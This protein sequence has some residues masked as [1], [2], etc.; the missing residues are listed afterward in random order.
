MIRRFLAEMPWCTNRFLRRSRVWVSFGTLDARCFL[1]LTT[2]LSFCN[3]R[4]RSTR[5]LAGGG[6]IL[7][8]TD[9]NVRDK[10]TG[11]LPDALTVYL[12]SSLPFSLLFYRSQC[13]SGRLQG[14][15]YL[16]LFLP[17]HQ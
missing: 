7:A 10:P 5:I 2:L 11:Y 15:L 13:L 14:R 9:Q 8:A 17:S 4:E 12:P 3:T 6:P 16:E 1:L